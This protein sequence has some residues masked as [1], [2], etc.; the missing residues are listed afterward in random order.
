LRR[1]AKIKS[2][3]PE[4]MIEQAT[5][6]NSSSRT[7]GHRR[8]SV[9]EQELPIAPCTGCCGPCWGLIADDERADGK[10][11]KE[12][13]GHGFIILSKDADSIEGACAEYPNKPK[14]EVP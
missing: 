13:L 3:S 10:L 9:I 11:K 7:F 8:K 12:F 6:Q 5:V 2:M 14:K 1:L 4:P